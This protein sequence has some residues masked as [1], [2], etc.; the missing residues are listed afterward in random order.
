MSLSP[1]RNSS[2]L[3]SILAVIMLSRNANKLSKDF[4]FSVRFDAKP[5]GK[6]LAG[7]HDNYIFHCGSPLP[8]IQGFRVTLCCGDIPDR[9]FTGIAKP[10]PNSAGGWLHRK[11]YWFPKKCQGRME[12]VLFL[13]P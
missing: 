10:S 2:I 1:C 13:S 11:T 4:D 9:H 8:L 3:G 7:W 6:T 5:R 12:C